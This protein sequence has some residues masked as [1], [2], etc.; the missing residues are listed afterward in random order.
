MDHPAGSRKEDRRSASRYLT[1]DPTEAG[2]VGREEGRGGNVS[3]PGKDL[4]PPGRGT[5]NFSLSGGGNGSLSEK[6]ESPESESKNWETW[7]R[8]DVYHA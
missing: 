6:F 8:S 2:K 3:P 5:G 1:T 7:H 4:G